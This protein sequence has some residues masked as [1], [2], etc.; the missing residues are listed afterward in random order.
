MHVVIIICMLYFSDSSDS[1][2]DNYTGMCAYER[3]R[4][5]RIRMNKQVLD[6]LEFEKLAT[7]NS[8]SVRTRF[9]QLYV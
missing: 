3:K 2:S 5:R 1:D 9:I 7:I 4:M 6:G 8:L